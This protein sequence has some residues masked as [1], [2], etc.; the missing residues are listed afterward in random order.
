MFFFFRFDG[1]QDENKK[2]KKCKKIISL[3]Y[4]ND[5]HFIRRRSNRFLTSN[6]REKLALA[7][8]STDIYFYHANFFFDYVIIYF[9]F[10]FIGT[11]DVSVISSSIIHVRPFNLGQWNRTKN[12]IVFK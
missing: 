12:T 11:D 9:F 5:F 8:I 1:S 6:A 3:Y 2:K 10:F 7:H 4:V